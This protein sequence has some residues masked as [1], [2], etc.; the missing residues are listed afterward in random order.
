MSDSYSPVQRHYGQ[1]HAAQGGLYERILAALKAMGKDPAQL[2]PDDLSPVDE[3][4]TLG[5]TITQRMA[6]GLGLTGSERV[7]DVGS[8]LGGPS[9]YLARTFGCAVTGLDLTPEFCDVADKLAALVGMAGRVTY[10]QGDALAMP[11]GA[12]SFD[13]VWSQ[14]AV[15]N[16][17]D[18]ARLYREI[19]RVLR[20]GGRYAFSDIMAGPGGPA[21]FPQPWASEAS[22][23]FLLTPE[24]TRAA[25]EAAGFRIVAWEDSSAQAQQAAQERIAAA[26]RPPPLGIHLLVAADWGT[27][28]RNGLKNYQ[29]QRIK[30]AGGV[31]QKGA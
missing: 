24:A 30:L 4:H 6:L 17:A 14:N 9:R 15:M 25:L 19:H 7:L 1:H 22:L 26:D 8:G 28:V 27:V 12:A 5:K 11:F 31:A 3:F 23:S 29:E 21:H 10:R 2:T 20:A 18:R 16:I 13:L